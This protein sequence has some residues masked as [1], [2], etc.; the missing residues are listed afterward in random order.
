ML[1]VSALAFGGSVVAQGSCDRYVVGGAGSD[2]GDCSDES[3]PCETVQYAIHQASGG[4]V[5]CVAD[6]LSAPGPTTYHET[7]AISRSLTLDGKWQATCTAAAFSCSF[8]PV[9]CAPENVV[10][11][12][13]GT[14]RVVTIQGDITPTVDCF[15]ITGG[16]AAGLG[17][18]PGT[19][20]ENDAGGGIYS[21]DAAP[22]IVNNVI[23]A[24]YGCDLC[25][26]A[27]GRGGGVYLLN[28]SASAVIS[29]NLIANNVADNST[30]GEGGGI[31]VRDSDAQIRHNTIQYNRAGL[32]AG[33]GGGIVVRD[34]TPIVADNDV[35]HNVA[36]QSVVG[37][38]GGI[39]VWSTTP[40]T[41]ERN[42]IEYNQAISGASVSNLI[43]RGGGICYLGNP[44]AT[45]TIRDNIIHENIASPLS[46]AGYGGGIYL[47]GLVSPSIVQGNTLDGN[48]AG[49]NSSGNGGG[50]YTIDSDVTISDN[51][52]S[53]NSATWAG[54]QGEGGGIYVEGGTALLQA[55]S[56]TSN[57]GAG[58]PGFPSTATG[59]GGGIAI[60]NSL[61]IV[62]DNWIVGNHA[63]NAYETGS[64]GGIYGL[65]SELQILGN[66]V[67]GNKATPGDWGYGGG[68][69][70]ED[71]LPLVD[72]NTI[73]NNVAADGVHGRGGGVRLTLCSPFTLTNNVVAR[74]AAS[75]LGSGV[76]V[77]VM[78][79]GHVAFNTL[80]DNSDGDGVGVHVD[81]GSDVALYANIILSHT[82]GIVNADVAGSS[83]SA[84]YTLFEANTTD[85]GAGVSSSHEVAGPAALLADY[86]LAGTSGAIDQAPP[87]SWVNH[88]I[89]GQ[90]RPMG[91]ASDVGADEYVPPIY[92]PLVLRAVP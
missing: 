33:D 24:N 37:M 80:V 64:G 71:S 12:A 55:N 29:G 63:T 34:G 62:Q 15:T 73:L 58:F 25:P 38:G 27:Y 23:T 2:S 78:S 53:G 13:G 84:D 54:A 41:L 59:Y 14:G 30:W 6:L 89:D 50:I 48:I 45:A 65:R 66:T 1:L 85:Y 92:L 75:E 11:D 56:I 9:A 20:V 79:G 3:Q 52:L 70:L 8:T 19:T 82:T 91:A 87:L 36:G 72:A 43:S 4:D 46:P 10:L 83:I 22:I 7:L 28:A 67:D 5:I 18:D 35:L 16:D 51:D 21:R 32:S 68:I 61:T 90:H 17:G 60:S 74:N 57:Y 77:A 49:F 47:E 76:A 42:T 31:M 69:Y 86:H 81:I 44:T 40:A 88:D 39:F 26:A